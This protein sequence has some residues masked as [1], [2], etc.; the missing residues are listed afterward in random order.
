MSEDDYDTF[1]LPKKNEAK[2][3]SIRISLIYFVIGFLW[4]VLSD[5]LVSKLVSKNEDILA[6]SFTKGILYVLATSA[7]LFALI[8]PSLKKIVDSKET[9]EQKNA[10]LIKANE[11]QKELHMAIAKEKV[12]LSALINSIPEVI[13]YKDASGVYLGCNKAAE[14]HIGRPADEIM[15]KT[16]FDLYT[17]D[18]AEV[19]R[20]ND[21]LIMRSREPMK[22]EEIIS[23]PDGTQMLHEKIKSP[24]FDVY[25]NVIGVIGAGRDITERKEKEEKILYLSQHDALTGLYNRAIFGEMIKAVDSPEHLPISYIIGDINGMKLINDAFGYSEG[26]RVLKE[27]AGVLKQVARSEDIISRIGG[28][29]FAILLPNTDGRTARKIADK[30]K[31]LCMRHQKE[32]QMVCFSI[33]LGYATKVK[34]DESLNKVMI[35]ANDSMLRHK[36]L[37]QNS[38]HSSIL[39]SIKSTMFEKSNETEEHAERLGEL[40]KM[41]G[42]LVG[43]SDE[44]LD[45]LELL[46]T[47][48]DI[49]KIC[50]DKKILT[51]T[52]KLSDEEW[53]EIRRHPE[54]GFRIAES[55]PELKHIAEYILCH[56][57]RWDGKGYPQ[58]LKGEEIP[59]LSRILAISDAYDAMTN[60]RAYRKAMSKDCASAEILKNAGAQ[61]DPN[62][63]SLFIEMVLIAE[64]AQVAS[65]S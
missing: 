44:Q 52:E 49:G 54:V 43:L 9:L 13:L 17:K 11:L 23:L 65:I 16:D 29:E 15:G 60:D 8:Y 31:S 10:E 32:E 46:S 34:A 12:L 25:N 27:I 7:L 39:M 42:S 35:R 28:D 1:S 38:M 26:D 4:I 41:L 3:R 22:N 36:L 53:M 45:E 64:S 33:T 40:S 55:T 50:V 58:G 47:L 6:L 57:E 30:I 63:S 61:F 24:L 19:Y 56:H 51:K 18:M 48:H 20:E 37:E 62:L 5:S 21:L 59:L 14:K 2:C